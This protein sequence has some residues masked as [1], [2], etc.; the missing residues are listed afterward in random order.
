MPCWILVCTSIG[1]FV[2]ALVARKNRRAKD[3]RAIGV[4][5]TASTIYHVTLHPFA[6]AIDVIVAHSV[7]ASCMLTGVVRLVRF[8]KCKDLLGILFGTFAAVVYYKKSSKIEHLIARERWHVAFHMAAHI[9][10]HIYLA[11]H[12]TISYPTE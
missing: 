1:F 5:A 8:K 12:D 9:A 4:M 7:A 10:L 2:P 3:A 6:K 11:G